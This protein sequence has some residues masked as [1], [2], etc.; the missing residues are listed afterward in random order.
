MKSLLKGVALFVALTCVVWIAVLWR[1]RATQRD[2]DAGD[3]VLYLGLLPIALFGLALAVR[4]A[5][6]GAL[7][8]Q[9]AKLAAAPPEA[10]GAA[11]PAQAAADARPVLA[12]HLLG[13]WVNVAGGASVGELLA[14]IEAGKP[15][16]KPDATLRDDDGLPVMSARVAELDTA[17][18]DADLA[19]AAALALPDAARPVPPARAVRALACLAAPLQEFAQAV[20]D[21]APHLAAVDD[22]HPQREPRFARVLAAWPADWDDA[23]CLAAQ[24]WISARLCEPTADTLTRAQWSIRGQRMT[25]AELLAAGERVLDALQRQGRDDPVALLACHCDLD[26]AGIRALARDQQLFHLERRPKAPMPGEGAALL[27]LSAKPW[28]AGSVA[29]GE[30]LRFDSPA[31]VRRSQSIDTPGRTASDDATRLVAHSLATARLAGDAIAKLACDA[32][33][34]T[35]RAT[36]LFAVTL[37]LLPGLDATEDLRLAGTICGRLGPAAPLVTLAMA[38]Q[39]AA[40]AGRP[41]VALSLGDTHWRMAAIVRPD[42]SPRAAAPA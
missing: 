16:P 25:G 13:A 39:Q 10:S 7:A 35:P 28:P 34:H 3:I 41:A 19:R 14:A 27:A 5:V 1:W 12:W 22:A 33:Q 24:D 18:V 36:E 42:T 26:A 11:A 38:A 29:G 23:T 2:M 40:D 8:K 15:R 6:G 21:W 20:N 30:R 4:W 31:I 37:A 32:D 9:D 17:A